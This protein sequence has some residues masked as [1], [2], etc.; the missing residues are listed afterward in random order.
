[1]RSLPAELPANLG[2]DVTG[3]IRVGI[4]GGFPSPCLG[5]KTLPPD[6]IF[7]GNSPVGHRPP[8]RPQPFL[9]LLPLTSPMPNLS[10]RLASSVVS[11]HHVIVACLLARV[12]AAPSVKLAVARSPR[13]D[14]VL[15]FSQPTSPRRYRMSLASRSPR[16]VAAVI[17]TRCHP[18]STALPS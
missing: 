17:V 11:P 16:S 13:E 12:A 3:G 15:P 4:T 10:P 6:F 9:L 7:D 18:S 2:G 14:R 1:M 8:P 5:A